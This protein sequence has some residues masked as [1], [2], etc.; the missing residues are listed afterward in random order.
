MFSIYSWKCLSCK[1]FLNWVE[2]RGKTFADDEEFETE[3]QNWLRKHFYATEF[4]ALVKR[5]D[6]CTNVDGG[7]IEK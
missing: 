4:D 5:C 2:K 3:A 7:Y 6:K 1:T